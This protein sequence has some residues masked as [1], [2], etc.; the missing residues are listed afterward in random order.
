MLVVLRIASV[1]SDIGVFLNDPGPQLAEPIEKSAFTS[2][3]CPIVGLAA[4]ADASPPPFRG[5]E[6]DIGAIDRDKQCV[7]GG[8]PTRQRIAPANARY[9]QTTVAAASA[10]ISDTS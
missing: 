5:E 9:S 3:L 1:R 6:A 2:L 4:R 7:F 10:V 8:R